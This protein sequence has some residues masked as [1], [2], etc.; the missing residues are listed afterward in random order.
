MSTEN[1]VEVAA[2]K[3]SE[4]LVGDVTRAVK[5][6]FAE[7]NKTKATEAKVLADNTLDSR[8][9][10]WRSFNDFFADIMI[11]G[12]TRGRSCSDELKNWMEKSPQLDA[13]IRA[14]TGASVATAADGGNVVPIAYATTI[15]ELFIQNSVVMQYG[16]KV[17]QATEVQFYPQWGDQDSSGGAYGGATPQAVLTEGTEY[18]PQKFA[19]QRKSATLKKYGMAL[20]YTIELS[21]WSAPG[22]AA[23]I[24][25]V[26]PLAI[27][28]EFDFEALNGIAGKVTESIRNANCAVTVSGDISIANLNYMFSRQLNKKKARWLFAD[29]PKNF[30]AIQ[31]LNLGGTANASP[32]YMPSNGMADQP[33]GTILGRPVDFTENW[34][35]IDGG[36]F[37]DYSSIYVPVGGGGV[38][39]Y[40]SEHVRFMFD[41][42]V[43]KFL[44]FADVLPIMYEPHTPRNG[45]DTKSTIVLLSDGTEA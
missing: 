21:R 45:S 35:D 23:L 24:S 2:N 4:K 20:P 41:E 10:G 9:G 15:D 27:S 25:Q 19:V 32:V 33:F 11:Y 36:A 8:T 22:I 43:M 26:A 38:E 14:V 7:M 18:V 42:F 34:N 5:A 1:E 30:N 29:T 39:Q 31:T 40:T 44:M 12:K 6:E 37:I 28:A 13:H 3:L 17:P 16:S